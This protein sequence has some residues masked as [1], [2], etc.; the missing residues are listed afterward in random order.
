MDNKIDFVIIWVDGNDPEWREEKCKYSLKNIVDDRNIRYRDW[1]NLRYWFRGV[2]KYAPWVNK[3]HFVTWGHLP[4]WLDTSNP[5]L[6]IVKHKDFIPEEYLPTFNSNAIELN[7]HRIKDLSE[8]FVYFNDDM[9]IINKVEPK[10]FFTDGKPCDSAILSPAIKDKKDAIGNI[11]LNNMAIV[12]TYFNKNLQM[13]SKINKWFNYRYEFG[14]IIKN[15]LLIPWNSF[16]GFYEFHLPSSFLKSTY[17][18][19]WSKEYDE[20]HETSSHKFRNLKLDVNQWVI[21][22]WQ[23]A[24]NCFAPRTTKF[25]KLYT[26]NEEIDL[27]NFFDKL[28]YKAVC[29]NDDEAIN[30][31]QFEE[32][33][34]QL[35]KSFM[36]ILPEKSSFEK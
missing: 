17:N 27:N 21:R 9:F 19:I 10:D 35:N 36:R 8:Q 13:K 6:N 7:L 14:Q 24:S 30:E 18:E 31:Q 23:L 33:K 11:E 15:V 28:K 5:K 1:E 2:E 3:I 34:K 25:G 20:L 32:M 16:T 22:D 29:L 4:D 26:L 12:N